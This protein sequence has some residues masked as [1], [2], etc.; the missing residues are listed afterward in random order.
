MAENGKSYRDVK[1][2]KHFVPLT[3]QKW[4]GIS[5]LLQAL[6]MIKS[7]Y[8]DQHWLCLPYYD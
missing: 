7:G 8:V 2:N 6:I 5:T 3:K 4:T 1:K